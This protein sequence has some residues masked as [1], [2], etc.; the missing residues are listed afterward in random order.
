MEKRTV[1]PLLMAE[2]RLT[3]DPVRGETRKGE[4]YARAGIA[5]DI[6]E[7][8]E[9]KPMFASIVAFGV[10]SH[11][12]MDCTKGQ[13]VKVSG[14]LSKRKWQAENGEERTGMNMIVRFLW[15]DQP[16]SKRPAR[17]RQAPAEDVFDAP[18]DRMP[19]PPAEGPPPAPPP[20]PAAQRSQ[21]PSDQWQDEDPD[22]VPF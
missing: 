15:P 10:V 18:P 11:D 1:F 16:S 14:P 4:P 13:A 8:V 9:D 3:R 7:D 20:P 2:G 5:I 21:R 17:A 6:S 22:D 19:D 12:L